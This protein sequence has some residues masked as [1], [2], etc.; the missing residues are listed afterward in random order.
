MNILVTMAEKPQNDQDILTKFNSF[1]EGES[2]ESMTYTEF[3]IEQII[4]FFKAVREDKSKALEFIDMIPEFYLNFDKYLLK[5]NEVHK[6]HYNTIQSFLKKAVKVNKEATLEACKSYTLNVRSKYPLQSITKNL[7]I[8]QDH[9]SKFVDLTVQIPLKDY[10]MK[11]WTTLREL[12]E[13]NQR[14][15]FLDYFFD[16]SL[17]YAYIIEAYLKEYLLLV[18]K[19]ECIFADKDFDVIYT[20]KET[21]GT[22][23]NILEG[24]EH[25]MKYVAIRNAVFHAN[26]SMEY[27]VNFEQ[28]KIVFRKLKGVPE[29]ISI[30]EFVENYFGLIQIVQTEMLAL[31]FFIMSLHRSQMKKSITSVTVFM[32]KFI[33]TMKPLS[34]EEINK[35]R[36]LFKKQ[37]K[38]QSPVFFHL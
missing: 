24:T 32:K 34:D 18:L 31:T 35:L 4:G 5:T 28:R 38:E 2:L 15:K 16:W 13:K 37:F 22:I 7:L 30:R 14:K 23:L 12:V 9:L 29:V 17:K 6:E 21:I 10:D 33:D 11:L 25:D 26:F 3:L 20:G 1:I 27:R 8:I 19:I 36:I